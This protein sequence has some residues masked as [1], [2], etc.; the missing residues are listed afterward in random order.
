MKLRS[1]DFSKNNLS[2]ISLFLEM[3]LTKAFVDL[4]KKAGGDV[5][6]ELEHSDPEKE[7]Y[8]R[9]QFIFAPDDREGVEELGGILSL[10]K[11]E[12]SDSGKVTFM[13]TFTYDSEKYETEPDLPVYLPSDD[14]DTEKISLIGVKLHFP[15]SQSG[16]KHTI[17]DLQ[18][19]LKCNQYHTIGNQ[20]TFEENVALNGNFLLNAVKAAKKYSEMFVKRKA[21]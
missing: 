5:T 3:P 8:A 21:E 17:I 13:C 19:C 16:L 11:S 9:L 10:I 18:T 12:G 20:V 1:P 14:S 6:K 15:E 7:Q 4:M 2:K